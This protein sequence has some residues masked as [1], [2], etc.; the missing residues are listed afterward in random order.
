MNYKEILRKASDKALKNKNVMPETY[1]K[2][3]IRVHPI[4]CGYSLGACITLDT[5]LGEYYLFVNFIKWTIIIGWQPFD[6]EEEL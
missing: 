6:K 5:M 4:P 2:F 3:G 1:K